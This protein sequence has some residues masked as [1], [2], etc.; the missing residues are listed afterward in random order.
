MVFID[1]MKSHERIQQQES[2]PKLSGRFQQLRAMR[3]TIES[4][5]G[6]RDHVDGNRMQLEATVASHPLDPFSHDCQG[7]LS[8][9][10]EHGARKGDLVA[11]QTSRPRGDAQ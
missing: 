7:I 9:V 10:D 11:I 6:S 1:S 8:Q 2:G 4:E 5:H 3:L